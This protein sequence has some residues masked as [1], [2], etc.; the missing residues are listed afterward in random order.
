MNGAQTNAHRFVT[1]IGSANFFFAPLHPCAF[2][3][4]S[5][6]LAAWIRLRRQAVLPGAVSHWTLTS[7]REKLIKIGAK[8]VPFPEETE[9]GLEKGLANLWSRKKMKK[10]TKKACAGRGPESKWEIRV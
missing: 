5:P 10:I 2:A 3:F 1:G 8:V 9:G 7:L 6:C 4:K